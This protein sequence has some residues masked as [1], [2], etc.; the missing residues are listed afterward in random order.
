MA[1]KMLV[2]DWRDWKRALITLRVGDEV[3][4]TRG[5]FD[6]LDYGYGITLG[7]SLPLVR[8]KIQAL[9]KAKTS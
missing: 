5:R 8:L 4:A 6:L 9:A 3:L 2:V 7:I 1:D